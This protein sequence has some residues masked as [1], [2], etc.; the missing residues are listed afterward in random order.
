MVTDLVVAIEL[1]QDLPTGRRVPGGIE[2]VIAVSR[3]GRAVVP[4]VAL[5]EAAAVDLMDAPLARAVRVAAEAWEAVALVAAG[6][7]DVV[8]EA[9]DV[10]GDN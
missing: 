4:E 8:A 7:V 10:A 5:L 3:A 6:V 2:W 1:A 9:V